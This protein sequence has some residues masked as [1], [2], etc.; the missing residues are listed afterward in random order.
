MAKHFIINH[1]EGPSNKK[2]LSKEELFQVIDL[3]KKLRKEL[4]LENMVLI[5]YSPDERARETARHSPS[6]LL[7]LFQAYNPPPMNHDNPCWFL[8]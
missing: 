5:H 2:S 4:S 1:G 7:L 8:F 6:T 3:A